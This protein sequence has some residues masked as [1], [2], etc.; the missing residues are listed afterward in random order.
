MI[1]GEATG[2]S[3]KKQ[4]AGYC[5]V[6]CSSAVG[7]REAHQALYHRLLVPFLGELAFVPISVGHS[8][9]VPGAIDGI[10]I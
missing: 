9:T 6:G 5:T 2:E 1:Y 4:P 3:G 10:F 7:G 8:L